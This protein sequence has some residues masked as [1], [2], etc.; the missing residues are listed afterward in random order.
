MPLQNPTSKQFLID[1]IVDQAKDE[2]VTLTDTEI[3]ML[4]FTEVT[5]TAKDL[6]TAQAFERDYDDE[7]YEKKIADLIRHAYERDKKAGNDESWDTALVHIAG[8]DLYLNVMIDRSGIEKGSFGPFGDWRFTF[9]TVL[10]PTLC[11]AAAV[12]IGFAPI[13]KTI[14]HNDGLRLLA[15]IILIATPFAIYRVSSRSSTARRN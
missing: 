14:I 11:L 5:A 15:V 13:G 7:A 4:G 1:R 9:Y 8:R 6:E 2:G 12:L 10:P 3:R